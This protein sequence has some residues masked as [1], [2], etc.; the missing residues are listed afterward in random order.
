MWQINL[1]ERR[2]FWVCSSPPITFIVLPTLTVFSGAVLLCLQHIW[3]QKVHGDYK[4]LDTS[5]TF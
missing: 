5:G 3:I 1:A 2:C 4:F